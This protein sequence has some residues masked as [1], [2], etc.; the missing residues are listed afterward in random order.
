M[1]SQD[2]DLERE[3]VACV[4]GLGGGELHVA[5]ERFPDSEGWDGPSGIAYWY[6][7]VPEYVTL[8]E[9]GLDLDD[10]VRTALL[11]CIFGHPAPPAGWTQVTTYSSSGERECCWCGPGTGNEDDDGGEAQG[12]KLCENDGYLY[13]GDGWCEVVYRRVA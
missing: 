11:C 5:D 4:F 8:D 13:L 3:R 12:C 10:D 1:A 2:I 6:D 9:L 7:G